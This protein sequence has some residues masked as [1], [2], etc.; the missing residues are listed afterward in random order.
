LAA[1]QN[2]EEDNPELQISMHAIARTASVA[3]TFL[4]F[5]TIGTTKLVALIDSGSIA[6]FM[7]PSVIVKTNL[8]VLNHN[9]VKVTVANGNTL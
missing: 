7:D 5:F 2:Q 8:H 6:I 1:Q 9:P 3:K 4:L